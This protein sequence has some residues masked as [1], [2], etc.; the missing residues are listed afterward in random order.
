[1]I[2]IKRLLDS[3]RQA[4]REV[5]V[6]YVN[7][8][9]YIVVECQDFEF[10]D[11]EQ[12]LKA[13][14]RECGF[15]V[16]QLEIALGAAEVS[17]LLVTREES[18]DEYGFILNQERGG[19]WLPLFDDQ[20]RAEW[21]AK[22]SKK[23]SNARALHF[24]GFKGGQA[25]STVLCTLARSLADSGYKIL[26]V[27][28]DLEA[29][30]M[31]LMFGVAPSSLGSS[32]LGICVGGADVSPYS[33]EVSSAGG[34]IDLIVTS[35]AIEGFEMDS[36]A[37][38]VRSS[39]D[40]TVIERGVAKVCDYANSTDQR[41]G[42][43]PRYDYILFDHRTGLSSSVLPV[44]GSCPGS[45]VINVRPDG[46]S[47]GQGSIVAALLSTNVNAP[48]A[49]VCFS[50]DPEKRKDSLSINEARI[51]DQLLYK[52]ADA[53]SIGAE[54][55]SAEDLDGFLDDYF[56]S[57]F[58]D[59]AFLDGPLA[60]LNDI[61]K[62]NLNSIHQLRRVLNIPNMPSESIVANEH[63]E[64]QSTPVLFSPS[65]ALDT[66]WFVETPDGTKLL[67]PTLPS[68]YIY[69]RKGTGKTRLFKEMASRQ[70]GRPLHSAAD[71]KGG[72][73]Q[74]QS[75]TELEL[76][77]MVEGDYQLFWWALL[78]S[79]LQAI[80][81]GKSTREVLDEM[82]ANDVEFLRGAVSSSKISAL[83]RQLD[84]KHTF[85]IDGVETAVDAGKTLS[86]VEAMFRFL[87][88]IQ[89]D[90]I[91]TD[92]IKF[93]VFIRSDLPVGVQ[94]VEQQVHGRKLDLRWHESSIFHYV[95]AELARTEWFGA[96]FPDVCRI[97]TEK[98]KVIRTAGLA[99]DEY[100][101]LLLRVFPQKLRRNNLSTM[102]FL[103]TYFSDAAGEGDSRSSFYPRVFGSFLSRIGEIG[104]ARA[105]K[106]LDAD[107]RVSHDVVLEAF[108]FAARDFINEVKQELNFALDIGA[109]AE[110]N[111]Q[112]VSVLLESFTGM[113]TP[114]DLDKCVEALSN[115]LPS[116]FNSKVVRDCLRRM[117]D[118][119]IFEDHP[120]DQR[121]WR[122]GRLFKEGLRMK[123]VRK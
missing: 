95:L 66:G 102:T 92:Q 89:N 79:D 93:K 101:D 43:A 81:L 115:K 21:S 77:S 1:M 28:A 46:L 72:G 67:Q 85:L 18:A 45:V 57:W 83:V 29:P 109:T 44:I 23:I 30:S 98:N 91:F 3:A 4:Y 96:N 16:E 48:G 33:V 90:V 119:G 52:M 14:A 103:R 122:A 71:F 63:L 117:K 35:P 76:L 86:F 13:F 62:A 32:L 27:D 36:A 25:R 15:D 78:V 22:H 39:L 10:Y 56:V 105:E 59:R 42:T 41:S 64:S 38:V 61:S 7:P 112:Y 100:E 121:K 19:H 120:V 17:L 107:Q 73:L 55:A 2:T 6:R 11:R 74:A 9:L 34:T 54:D 99:Q 68:F 47:D 94:N 53:I 97:I 5:T 113:P 58:H 75:S 40:T 104:L 118:M 24:Y 123:Y 26:V 111:R 69:G 12:R 82:L 50:L 88:T 37:F 8:V 110:E 65:G 114:F 87:S 116:P 31:H 106:A 80:L 20:L 70:L 60:A 49:F 108:E 84:S 51:K